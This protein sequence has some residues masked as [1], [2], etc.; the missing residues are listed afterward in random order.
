MVHCA[1]WYNS[2]NLK[3]VKNTH[4]GALLLV[5]L[6]ASGT[7]LHGYLLRFLNC[8]NDTNLRKASQYETSREIQDPTL[9]QT[10]N[11][12]PLWSR[13]FLIKMSASQKKTFA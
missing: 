2:N 1:I 5:K 7:L 11:R 4:G 8:T 12:G 10:K 6:L 13:P 3:N 9:L